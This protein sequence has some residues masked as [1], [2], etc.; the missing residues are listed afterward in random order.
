MMGVENRILRL[1]VSI[2]AV[3]SKILVEW[4]LKT[5]SVQQPERRFDDL[6]VH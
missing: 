1:T 6:R 4:P 2:M 5:L 3:R